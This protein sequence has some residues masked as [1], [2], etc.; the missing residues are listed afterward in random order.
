MMH[1]KQMRHDDR[2]RD[3]LPLRDSVEHLPD[4]VR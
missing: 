2:G 3:L 1:L 4:G